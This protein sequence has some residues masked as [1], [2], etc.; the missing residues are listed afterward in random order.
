MAAIFTIALLTL[1]ALA[2]AVVP[3]TVHAQG[4]S[5]AEKIVVSYPSKS[6]TNFPILETARQ[7]GFFQKENLQVSLVYIRGGLDIKT[8]LTNDADFAMGSTTAVTAFVAG[9]PLR[10]IL[11]YNAHVDQGLYAQ[12]KYRRIADLKGQPI[13]SLNPGGLVDTMVRRILIKNGL[14]PERDVNLLAMGG[15]PERFAAL[16]A[17]AIAATMLSS[18]FNF[19]ADKE[20][21]SKL[22][23]TREYVDVPGTAVVVHADKIKKQPNTLKR[24]MRASLNAM[25]YIRDNRSDT[26]RLIAREFSMDQEVAGLAYGQ[27]L[28]LLSP[29]GRNRVSGYQLLV[30]FARAGQKIERPINAAQL[31][32]ESL[33]D[34]LMREGG[35]SK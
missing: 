30:D 6:I 8:L 14:Q 2:A 19:L 21:F 34:E 15:T 12:A 1:G 5:P 29:D 33:L 27:L 4:A 31:I 17:G 16:R 18:P 11:S 7:K 32:D 26:T 28:E 25:K 9:A 10:I 35:I 3:A 22:A 13:G 23:T 24:F 20:G